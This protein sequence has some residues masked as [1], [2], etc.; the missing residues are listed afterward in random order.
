MIVLD[1]DVLS[2][3]MLPKPDMLIV[4][5]LD[6]Q[7]RI[8]VWTT[9]ITVFEV[10]FG[11]ALLPVG[12]RRGRLELAFEQLTAE[13]I[14]NRVLP[15]DTSA[16]EETASLMAERRRSGRTG[17]LRDAMIAGIAIARHAT[18]A[19]RNTRHFADLPVSVV[20]PWSA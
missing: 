18:L 3:L 8:S 13:M 4:D 2:G 11:I 7:A 17:E 16:A 9:S 12:S 19:T 10:R 1:T 15:F 14:E 5:W 6:R 20:D